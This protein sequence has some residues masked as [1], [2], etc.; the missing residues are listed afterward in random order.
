[1]ENAGYVGG[2]NNDDERILP[3]VTVR[4]E[5]AGVLPHR[6]YAVLELFV[7]KRFG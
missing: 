6:V 7:I 3:A 5:V 2:R 4:A 1:M